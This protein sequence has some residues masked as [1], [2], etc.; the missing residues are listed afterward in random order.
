MEEAKIKFLW[1]LFQQ[2]CLFIFYSDK[3]FFKVKAKYNFT[4]VII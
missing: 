2:F 1:I 3:S 4:K